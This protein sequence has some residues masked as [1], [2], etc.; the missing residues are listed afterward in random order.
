M[1]SI[2]GNAL[3]TY[4]RTCGWIVWNL[5]LAYIPLLLSFVL[6]RRDKLSRSAWW[7]IGCLIFIAFL[8]N[9]PYML[10]D[11]IHLIRAVRSGYS[12]WVIALIFIPM[13]VVAI[14][15][16]FEAYVI[17]LMNIGYYLKK[18]RAAKY[19]VWVELLIHALC[20]VGVYLGRFQRFN[21]WD[22]VTAPGNILLT[23]IDNLTTKLPVLVMV[24]I[25]IVISVFY[26]VM[27]QITL[28]IFLRIRYARVDFDNL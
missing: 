14:V 26:W 1:E 27:K 24:I 18:L 21:S 20:A 28:G 5:F 9:A 25:F 19:I 8:P 22:F 6:F 3:E 7:W 10:T 12:A 23:T 16:G 13:H 2:L 4:N 15:V 11:I 17:S